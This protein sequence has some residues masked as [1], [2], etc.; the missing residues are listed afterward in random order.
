MPRM[1]PA[2]DD[3]RLGDYEIYVV[4]VS[5]RAVLVIFGSFLSE[6]CEEREV[7]FR[8]IVQSVRIDATD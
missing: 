8:R 5:T 6:T 3:C 1:Q 2:R 7:V 4:P